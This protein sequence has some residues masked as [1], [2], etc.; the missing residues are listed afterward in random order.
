MSGFIFG[1]ETP[2]IC[3]G[4]SRFVR[5]AI[6]VHIVDSIMFMNVIIFLKLYVFQK[7]NLNFIARLALFVT[8]QK[9]TGSGTVSTAWQ[10]QIYNS[11]DLI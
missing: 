10:V 9:Y 1:H 3:S 11:F 5:Q 6:S 2:A 4:H 7:V 8:S